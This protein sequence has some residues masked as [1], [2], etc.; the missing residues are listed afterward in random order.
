MTSEAS[1]DLVQRVR[2][3]V[4][5]ELAASVGSAADGSPRIERGRRLVAQCLERYAAECLASGRQLPD[6]AAEDAMAAAVLNS[7]FG[8]GGFQKY[9][10]DPQVED[11]CANG[12]DCVWIRYA[13][14]RLERGEPVAAS[15]AELIEILR[16][17]AARSGARRTASIRGRRISTWIC[18]T[19]AGSSR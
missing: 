18:R 10:D 11:I 2:A 19:A 13:G 14:G 3:E 7:F 16:E 12:Y 17:I 9:L 8:L 15:D 5:Q 6:P 4:A 1:T